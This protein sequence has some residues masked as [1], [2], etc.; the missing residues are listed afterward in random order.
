MSKR[1]RF[2][3]GDSKLTKWYYFSLAYFGRWRLKRLNK[4]R[5][6]QVIKTIFLSQAYDMT[7]ANWIHWIEVYAMRATNRTRC[8]KCGSY[9][10]IKEK[11]RMCS[12]EVMKLYNVDME[13]SIE[14]KAVILKQGH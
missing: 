12:M 2:Y 7:I 1:I 10:I 5:K 8:D 13:K 9:F 11:C 3:A 4:N 6:K 14:A